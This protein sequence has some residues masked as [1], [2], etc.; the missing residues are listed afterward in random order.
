MKSEIQTRKYVGLNN[1]DVK[2]SVSNPSVAFSKHISNLK[3]H[4]G[5]LNVCDNL[6]KLLDGSQIL[7]SHENCGKVQDPYSLRCI[8]Q[9]H[10]AARMTINH[11]QEL[12]EV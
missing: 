4:K 6:E 1:F 3:P 8:P 10:G 2:K 12:S 9:V 11:F 7:N 5:Q